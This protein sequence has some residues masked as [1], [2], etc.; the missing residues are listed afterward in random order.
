MLDGSEYLRA[1]HRVAFSG[2]RG[3]KHRSADLGL[4]IHHAGRDLGGADVYSKNQ[5]DSVAKFAF[6][7]G[8]PRDIMEFS[9]R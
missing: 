8:H 3:Q 6:M 1:R 9:W 4:R 5:P 2:A 7:R